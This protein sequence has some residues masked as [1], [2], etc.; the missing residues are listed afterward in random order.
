MPKAKPPSPAT[1]AAAN[2]P[3]RNRRV[4]MLKPRF[5][6]PRFA[7]MTLAPKVERAALAWREPHLTGRLRHPRIGESS[8]ILTMHSSAWRPCFLGR[9]AILH[10]SND[11][12]FSNRP[13]EV[14]RFQAIH[15]CG[16]GITRGLVLLFGLGARPFQHGIR[17]QGGTIFGA[18]L[19]DDRS[20]RTCELT[21]SIVPRGTSFHRVVELEVSSY[22]I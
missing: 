21:S 9:G 3:P 4:K 2:V 14:K 7:P 5:A 20:K 13:V 15:D 6:S 18:T 10:H 12:R 17:G 22:R 19:P 8:L 11:V 16:V 1:S